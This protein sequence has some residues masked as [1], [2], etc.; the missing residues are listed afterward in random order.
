MPITYTPGH[1]YNS[2][3][4]PAKVNQYFHIFEITDYN[5]KVYTFSKWFKTERVTDDNIVYPENS[6]W[7][8]NWPYRVYV[9]S[10]STF[11]DTPFS[12]NFQSDDVTKSPFVNTFIT[13]KGNALKNVIKY[14]DI[15]VL[16]KFNYYSSTDI[17]LENLYLEPIHA[18]DGVLS[19]NLYLNSI[20]PN[21]DY[22]LKYKG[23]INANVVYEKVNAAERTKSLSV[24]VLAY[25]KN[26]L[27]YLNSGF[28]SPNINNIL[29]CNISI[30]PTIS[31]FMTNITLDDGIILSGRNN[32][33]F[34]FT[35]RLK[36]KVEGPATAN[37]G[38]VLTYTVTIM[39]RDFTDT[40]A[41]PPNIEMYPSTTAGTIS[42]RKLTLVN[43]T[44][45]FKIDT[46]LLLSGESFKVK[47][48]WKYITCDST[49]T[50][51]LN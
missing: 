50:T 40:I 24:N 23:G 42:H 9:N 7:V 27:L 33:T 5:V 34:D 12:S 6:V 11:F 18:D 1:S 48:N 2:K 19:K 3:F 13:P 36:L 22:V 20:D 32:Y 16:N 47:A 38:D 37:V 14:T 26:D 51:T 25:N 31:N 21:I 15:A 17:D 44:G 4:D 49:V 10:A 45:Q 29:E 46:S 43:G 35:K 8:Q 41:N 39:N 30:G 28:G